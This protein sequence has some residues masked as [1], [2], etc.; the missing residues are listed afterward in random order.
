MT[1]LLPKPMLLLKIPPR[2]PRLPPLPP[3]PPRNV[4]LILPVTVAVILLRGVVSK[5]TFTL[6]RRLS[7]VV[8]VVVVVVDAVVVVAAR[9]STEEGL[10]SLFLPANI[11]SNAPTT[12]CRSSR[13]LPAIFGSKK[14][15]ST[16]RAGVAGWSSSNPENSNERREKAEERDGAAAEPAVVSSADCSER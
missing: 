1:W 13:V 16:F 14:G 4:V 9:C 11:A 15:M 8:V 10:L 6:G 5:A 3:P 7:L 2:M 12:F